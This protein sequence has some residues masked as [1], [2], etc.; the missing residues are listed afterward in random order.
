M[1][2]PVT[3]AEVEDVLSSIRRLVSED[4]RPL[5][6]ERKEPSNDRLV[7]TPALR[8]AQ[9]DD[10]ETD[11]VWPKSPQSVDG[12][13]DQH[14]E[15]A[16]GDTQSHVPEAQDNPAVLSG[17]FVSDSHEE[18]RGEAEFDDPAHDYD[19]DPYNFSDETDEDGEGGQAE[20]FDAQPQE[21]A[22]PLEDAR[23]Q[24][25]E[26]ERLHEHDAPDGDAEQATPEQVSGPDLSELA[27]GL[28]P[29]GSP[30]LDLPSHTSKAAVLSAKI[31]E[32]E[33]AIG[34]ISGNWETE[35][36]LGEMPTGGAED[37]M[38]WEDASP[39]DAIMP[40]LHALH[41]DSDDADAAAEMPFVL[42]AEARAPDD[43][44]EEYERDEQPV[45]QESA[46][47]EYNSDEQIIDEEALRD[48]VSEIVRAELQGDLGER[49]TRNV[50]K[51]V[52][53]EI[54]RALTAQDLE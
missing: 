29:E 45:R 39:E 44:A 48:M 36:D 15:I 1:S 12:N 47:F 46:A 18:D 10:H 26:A 34:N 22:Q 49:I 43:R 51:L 35:S 21:D 6:V 24:E 33:T 28:E 11:N 38:A 9:D 14:A 3:N 50:R 37:A 2:D 40:R 19:A 31:E 16:Q 17:A 4:K 8:V 32:L 7:L 23:P 41:P 13:D 25:Y 42:G 5:Q 30:H 54:H 53:R 52:R 27:C 20:S